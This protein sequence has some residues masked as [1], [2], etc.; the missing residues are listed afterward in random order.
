MGGKR[1][2][3]PAA[4]QRERRQGAG[5]YVGAACGAVPGRSFA[6]KLVYGSVAA[7]RGAPYGQ[8]L[9]D[10]LEETCVKCRR[11]R[12]TPLWVHQGKSRKV[13]ALWQACQGGGHPHGLEVT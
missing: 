6:L 3:I 12:T 10:S 9:W 11:K 5:I 1:E 7:R 4:G 2:G 13:R 8:E